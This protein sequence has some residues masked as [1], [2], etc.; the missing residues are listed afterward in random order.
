MSYNTKSISSALST[1][2]LFLSL[3]RLVLLLTLY[4]SCV[5]F[6]FMQMCKLRLSTFI[7]RI[8]YALL[9]VRFLEEKE[10]ER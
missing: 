6:A 1:E 2:T 7:K 3:Y 9:S 5:L 10:P 8:C 4:S